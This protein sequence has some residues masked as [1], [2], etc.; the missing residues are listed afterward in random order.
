MPAPIDR[1]D[2]PLVVPT[3]RHDRFAKVIGPDAKIIP[4]RQVSDCGE[5][6]V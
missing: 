3:R 2:L 1:I 6:V 5:A 4:A